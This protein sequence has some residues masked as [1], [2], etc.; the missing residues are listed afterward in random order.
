MLFRSTEVTVKA[1]APTCTKQGKTEGKKCSVCDKIIVEQESV[2]VLGHDYGEYKITKDP[3]CTAQGEETANCTRCSATKTQ[4]VPRISHT[5]VTVKSVAPTCT[6]QGETEGKKCSV[7]DKITVEQESIEVLGHD[8]GEYKITKEP[9]CSAKGEKTAECTRCTYIKTVDIAKTAHKEVTLKAVAPTCVKNGKTE[10]SRCSVCDKV[11]VAQESIPALGHTKK[12]V[13]LVKATTKANGKKSTIC[14][15][16]DENF[17][18]SR[19]YRIQTITLAK[20][21]YTCDGKVKK[22][23]VTVIDYNKDQLI[24]DRDYTV[25][26]QSGCKNVGRYSVKITF[27]GSYSGTTTLYFYIIPGKTASIKATAGTTAVTLKWD[28]VKGASGYKVYRYDSKTAGYKEIADT[29]KTQYK[30]TGLKNITTYKLAVRAYG[31]DANGKVYSGSLQGISVTTK[32]TTP[33]ISVKA[34][35]KTVAI[36]W[37]KISSVTG[38]QVWYSTKEN[39][40]YKKLTNT[41]Q[42][43][44]KKSGLTSGKKY[45]FKV[46]AYKKVGD[47]IVY[48]SFSAVKAVKIK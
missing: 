19:I 25:T 47:T 1:V 17:G 35:G 4:S 40:E 42:L 44:Y 41:N 6:K 21:K 30:I 15:V 29:A 32:P 2:V 48:S 43:T 11:V 9:T 14:S 7:C 13:V 20:E 24:K 18:E 16:C 28:S 26:Y 33:E 37:N 23:A 45:Y 38:Y 8:L 12:A 27:K 36:S 39:G 34:S 3:T 10:G 31:K 22:P 46:R 5:E